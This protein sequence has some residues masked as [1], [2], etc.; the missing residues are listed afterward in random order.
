MSGGLTPAG[1]EVGLV[2]NRAQNLVA[3]GESPAHRGV[4]GIEKITPESPAIPQVPGS[5]LKFTTLV[6]A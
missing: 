3:G 5:P 1:A 4:C 6:T 2:T